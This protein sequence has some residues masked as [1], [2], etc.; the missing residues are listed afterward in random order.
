MDTSSADIRAFT[1]SLRTCGSNNPAERPNREV[2][3]R[4]NPV[5]ICPSRAAI[6]RLVGAPP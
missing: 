3:R 2:R 5:G 4:T 1:E 6:V